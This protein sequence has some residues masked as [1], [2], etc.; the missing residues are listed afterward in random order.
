MIRKRA[1][2]VSLEKTRLQKTAQSRVAGMIQDC[3]P[4]LKSG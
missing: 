3:T 1:H 2:S 4:G